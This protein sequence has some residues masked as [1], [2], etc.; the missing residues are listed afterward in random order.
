MRVY[1]VEGSKHAAIFRRSHRAVKGFKVQGLWSGLRLKV[2]EA[3]SFRG[4]TGLHAQ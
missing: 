1:V 3:L 2:V 4:L